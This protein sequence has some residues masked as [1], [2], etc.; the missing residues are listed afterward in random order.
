MIEELCWFL[1]WLILL[2]LVHYQFKVCVPVTICCLKVLES[3]VLLLMV[4]IYV[5]FMIYGDGFNI[6][7]V[8]NATVELYKNYASKF[9]L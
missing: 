5:F 7:L 9:E 2:I 1:L 6:D 8:K 3:F 4:K